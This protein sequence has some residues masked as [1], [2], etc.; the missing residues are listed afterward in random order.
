MEIG[1][2]LNH[3]VS[4]GIVELQQADSIDTDGTGSYWVSRQWQPKNNK[5]ELKLVNNSTDQVE[6]IVFNGEKPTDSLLNK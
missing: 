3:D 4:G 2:L 5:I 6:V 1:I